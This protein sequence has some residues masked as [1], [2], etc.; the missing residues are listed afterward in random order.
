VG[1][2]KSIEFFELAKIR[3]SNWEN[4]V[5]NLPKD[6]GGP[7]L[8]SEEEDLI[9]DI[10]YWARNAGLGLNFSKKNNFYPGPHG[11]LYK[12]R[13]CPSPG[14]GCDFRCDYVIPGEIPVNGKPPKD[15]YDPWAMRKHC[16]SREHIIYIVKRRLRPLLETPFG[17]SVL[18]ILMRV[19][20]RGPLLY[21]NETNGVVQQFVKD[22][23]A[24]RNWDINKHFDL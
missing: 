13:W 17:T 11:H 10:C 20:Q 6:C 19:V 16:Q 14:E 24:G 7:Y 12:H 22:A 15:K 9:V 21:V 8:L 2:H 3:P 23:V 4:Y 1:M 5:E 18:P